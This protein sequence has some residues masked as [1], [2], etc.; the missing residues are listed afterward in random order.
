M[1]TKL[2]YIQAIYIAPNAGATM[3]S[4]SK[5]KITLTGIQ[6]DRYANGKGAYSD[7]TPSK[8]RHL[9]LIAESGIAI[10][11]EW[12]LAGEEPTFDAS[13]TRRNIVI[14]NMSADDLNLL[15]GKTFALGVL[16][17]K[18]VELCTPCERPA[19]LLGKPSFMDAFEGRGGL[20]AEIILAGEI[21][22]GDI[23]RLQIKD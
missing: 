22:V 8:I 2:P 11:N 14:S 20:R 19:Q 17:L 7:T 16:I 18:G 1:S 4:L 21:S 6:G 12:L 9:S 23:L 15:V 3:Q 13:Q 10:A 5:A